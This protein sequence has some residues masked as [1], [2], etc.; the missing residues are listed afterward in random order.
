M[1]GKLRVVFTY[2]L[3]LL[4]IILAVEVIVPR[5]VATVVSRTSTIDRMLLRVHIGI[6]RDIKWP[7]IKVT[8]CCVVVLQISQVVFLLIFDVDWIVCLVEWLSFTH[9]GE[10][11]FTTRVWLGILQRRKS[12]CAF[13]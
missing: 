9:G 3:V 10:G 1:G 13:R 7:L 4:E 6:P 12:L 8:E 5:K 2:C 11:S